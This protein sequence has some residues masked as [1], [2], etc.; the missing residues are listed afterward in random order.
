MWDRVK[1]ELSFRRQLN[2]ENTLELQELIG[3]LKGFG[4][5]TDNDQIVWPYGK[6]GE[7]N[8]RSLY[9]SLSFGGVTYAGSMA[10]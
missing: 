7:Y 4:I 10:K 2:E 8:A 5:T 1:L 9:R 6:K 3:R